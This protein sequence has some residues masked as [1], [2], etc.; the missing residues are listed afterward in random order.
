M[1][2]MGLWGCFDEGGFRD[3]YDVRDGEKYWEILDS[4]SNSTTV[5]K[6]ACN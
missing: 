5:R 1:N 6:A 2:W 3:G 4:Q